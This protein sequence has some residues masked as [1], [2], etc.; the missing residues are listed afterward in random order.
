MRAIKGVLLALTI[1]A[2]LSACA[3]LKGIV[4]HHFAFDVSQ[5]QQNA[6]ILDFRYGASK[7]PVRAPEHLVKKNRPFFQRS[8]SGPMLRGDDLYMKWRSITT[9]NVYEATVDLRNVLPA[10]IDEH[11]IYPMVKESQ[12]FIYLVTPEVRSH[13]TLAIGPSKYKSRKII[14]IYPAQISK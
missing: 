13:D 5:D 4:D 10:N 3:T 12:L 11:I 2:A 14:Q 7:A 9:G 8:V 6:V 1:T